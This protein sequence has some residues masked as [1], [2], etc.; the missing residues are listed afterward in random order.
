[1]TY[2]QLCLLACIA[3]EDTPSEFLA[4]EE[5]L[6]SVV[7]PAETPFIHQ[8]LVKLSG[9][10]GLIGYDHGADALLI[11]K[12]PNPLPPG[13]PTSFGQTCAELMGLHD[14]TADDIR[15]MTGQLNV[16]RT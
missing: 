10:L 8:A 1:M 16:P 12:S 14:V 4:S 6:A 13:K 2:R 9:A 3:R 5:S 15:L 7:P 11:R